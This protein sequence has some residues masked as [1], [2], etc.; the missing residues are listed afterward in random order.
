MGVAF[1]T[2]NTGELF[3][4]PYEM[5]SDRVF[6][7]DTANTT[8]V[9]NMSAAAI[10]TQKFGVPGLHVGNGLRPKTDIL[11]HALSLYNKVYP[12][13]SL[14]VVIAKSERRGGR[15]WTGGGSGHWADGWS[16]G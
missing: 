10:R 14:R 1:I 12:S 16:P 15:G 9:S 7:G 3:R 13:F 2:A 6:I 4:Y 11:I 8:D 5:R